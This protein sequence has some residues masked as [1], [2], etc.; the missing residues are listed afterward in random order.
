MKEKA[1]HQVK[2]IFGNKETVELVEIKQEKIFDDE[3]DTF[4]VAVVR[5]EDGT[6]SEVDP[7]K[8]VKL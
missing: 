6:V 5:Y 8:L 2:D 1:I 7:A 3:V 4:P